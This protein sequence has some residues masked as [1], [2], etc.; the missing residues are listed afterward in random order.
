[1]DHQAYLSFPFFIIFHLFEM[2]S[3]LELDRVALR[4]ANKVFALGVVTIGAGAGFGVGVR[5]GGRGVW[6]GKGNEREFW[7]VH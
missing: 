2:C 3:R 5:I 7:R 4:C 6:V 1:M